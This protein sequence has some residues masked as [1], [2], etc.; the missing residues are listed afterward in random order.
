MASAAFTHV[1]FF[2]N[3]GD[4]AAAFS[5]LRA[6]CR[7]FEAVLPTSLIVLPEA[8]NVE[9]FWAN[10]D[11]WI[12]RSD[13]SEGL[14]KLAA[15]G[16][17]FVAGLAI[18]SERDGELRNCACL[19]AGQGTWV[20]SGKLYVD[21]DAY[22]RSFFKKATPEFKILSH[23]GL[24]IAGLVCL[25]AFARVES[26]AIRTRRTELLLDL[27]DRPNG[28]LC[29]PTLTGNGTRVLAAVD[30]IVNHIVANSGWDH[31]GGNAA[32]SYIEVSGRRL[33]CTNQREN[34][35]VLQSLSETTPD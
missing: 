24:D 1:G 15:D 6:Q 10:S 17:T 33:A 29:V 8:F 9:E 7:D 16:A 13:V 32:A 35:L 22:D 20:L 12:L 11:R 4:R 5:D 2:H 25:D 14:A 21:R 18:R 28:I 23:R 26:E 34:K 27:K 3:G 19:I 31:P 30:P